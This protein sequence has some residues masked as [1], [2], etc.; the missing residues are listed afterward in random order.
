MRGHRVMRGREGR[1]TSASEGV[2]EYVKEHAGA[3][4][5]DYTYIQ[6]HT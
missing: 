2:R 6:T 1:G 4:V 3:E 5:C